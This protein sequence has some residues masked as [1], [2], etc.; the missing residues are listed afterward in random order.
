MKIYAIITIFIAL[1]SKTA[2]TGKYPDRYFVS[3]VN[4]EI[5]L[6]G[7]FG[8]LRPNHFH[9]GLDIKSLHKTS[10]DS[11]FAAGDGYISR[12]NIDGS[13]YGNAIYINHPNGYTTLYGH[14]DRFTDEIQNYVK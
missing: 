1:P 13:G 9:T 5:K 10:G 8:E 6:A 12:I 2:I 3:P 7:T 14:L 11:V 4:R